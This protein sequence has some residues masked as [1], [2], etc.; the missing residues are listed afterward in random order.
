MTFDL[1]FLSNIDFKNPDN[2]L[3]LAIVSLI[4]IIILVVF[5][6]IILKTIKVARR[7]TIR[8]FSGGSKSFPASPTKNINQLLPKSQQSSV[9][10]GVVKEVSS[11]PQQKI[12]GGNSF[13]K[14][15]EKDKQAEKNSKDSYEE[16]EKKDIA[17]SLGKMKNM[18]SPLPEGDQNSVVKKIN[19]GS[20][21]KIVKSL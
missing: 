9:V 11:G 6:I 19:I 4:V 7:A 21:I 3:F 13:K 10:K 1:S 17:E 5:I 2:I 18:K 8:T 16:K 20:T 12:M 14:P 15:S